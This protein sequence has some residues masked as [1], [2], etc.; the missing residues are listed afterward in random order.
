[1]KEFDCIAQT[2]KSFNH[3]KDIYSKKDVDLLKKAYKIIAP[4]KKG[5][6][7][8]LI[9]EFEGKKYNG[10]IVD[11]GWIFEDLSGI[12]VIIKSIKKDSFGQQVEIFLS[13]DNDKNVRKAFEKL[14]A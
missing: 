9:I 12:C 3:T 8:N 7:Y 6:Y 4:Y 10:F 13:V 2:R 5:S 1:M 11:K 14:K